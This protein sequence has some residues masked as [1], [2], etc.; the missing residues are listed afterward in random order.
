[1]KLKKPEKKENKTLKTPKTPEK[2]LNIPENNQKK[3]YQKYAQKYKFWRYTKKYD[4]NL[5]SLIRNTSALSKI[6]LDGVK[7][8]PEPIELK[9]Y[10]NEEQEN[11]EKMQ[12]FFKANTTDNKDNRNNIFKQIPTENEKNSVFLG[13]KESLKALQYF[14][15]NHRKI[16]RNH[17]KKMKNE[18]YFP[19]NLKMIKES[20]VIALPINRKFTNNAINQYIFSE[21]QC[22]KEEKS[23]D[24]LRKI[25]GFILEDKKLVKSKEFL[26][27]EAWDIIL[28]NEEKYQLIILDLRSMRVISISEVFVRNNQLMQENGSINFDLLIKCLTDACN[29]DDKSLLYE[30]FLYF[31]VRFS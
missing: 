21:I 25:K 7:N 30:P 1:M 26:R 15:E 27:K 10:C 29:E 16:V 14:D 3:D 22:V 4:V 9:E 5:K 24:L 19:Q 6:Y 20:R 23:I 28:D 11:E 18:Q 8:K 2:K 31:L 17:E 13:F 12:A